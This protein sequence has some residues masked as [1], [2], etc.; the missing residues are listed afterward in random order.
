MAK[1]R[2]AK[3]PTRR[4]VAPSL[5]PVSTAEI[6][7]AAVEHLKR[8]AE[9]TVFAQVAP[10]ED[11]VSSLADELRGLPS[12]ST[13]AEAVRQIGQ[14]WGEQ[15]VPLL[16]NLA[17]GHDRTIEM[18]SVRTLGKV[19]SEAAVKALDHVARAAADKDVR[20]EARRSLFKLRSAGLDVEAILRRERPEPERARPAG[21]TVWRAFAS[22]YDISGDRVVIAAVE[23][24]FGG[25]ESATAVIH[26][27]K[28]IVA[29]GVRDTNKRK[30]LR[31]EIEPIDAPSKG[32]RIVEIPADYAKHLLKVAYEKNKAAGE[33]VPAEFHRLRP[34]L[35]KPEREY[36]RA[37]IY[38]E[39]SPLE[40]KWN[41]EYLEESSHLFDLPEFLHWAI[42]PD[43][44]VEFA[45][46]LGD[47]KRGT[48]ALPP[49]AEKER[50]AGILK[51]ALEKLFTPEEIDR[52]KRQLEETAY[53]LLHTERPKWAKVALAAAIALEGADRARL[54]EN[55]FV[56][57]LVNES[58]SD[59]VEALEAESAEERTA[60]GGRLIV[61]SEE[62]SRFIDL[63]S[64]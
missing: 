61:A 59:V 28:G 42:S 5:G 35:T 49:W 62:L 16:Q 50:E 34:V 19:R 21:P 25:I 13:A 10:A 51:R 17:T 54:V 33:G 26:E 58:M 24:P 1:Q 38:D 64:K 31:D 56:A 29:F 23:K 55:P 47:I 22:T 15:A 60:A 12:E 11:A 41:P 20:K 3:K 27:V 57:T 4:A 8:R 45:K 9:T 36:E 30:W 43:K 32:R 2:S 39:I 14:S 52:Y 7:Y 6:D 18:Q 40:I 46:E 63:Y 44:M 48:I 37:I 53:I